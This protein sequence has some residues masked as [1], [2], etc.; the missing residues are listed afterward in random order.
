MNQ[1]ILVVDDEREM[2]NLLKLC[3]ASEDVD[4][5]EAVNGTEAMDLIKNKTVSLVIL[6]IMMPEV[7]G[8]E[9]LKMLRT[10]LNEAIPVILLSALGDTE[11]VVQGLKLGADD[12]I[13]KPF[14]P[15]ELQA[16]AESVIRR[17]NAHRGEHESFT[18]QGITI[19]PKKYI[20]TF[21]K[22][23][24]ALTNKEFAIL[25]RLATN[26]GRIYTREQLLSLEWGMD[27]GGDTR[28]V[29]SH[30][31]NVRVK[32]N[33]AGCNRQVIETVWGMGYRINEDVSNE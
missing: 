26:P 2:R 10:E 32:L 17:V 6:D 20:V 28:T 27:F 12:Y 11:R 22:H 31:K 33:S 3:L 16:R 13:V 21:N 5:L 25:Y 8:F 23:E 24:L 4:I 30:V 14:E 1:T 29:D 19:H 15:S 9:L 7:D 18:I